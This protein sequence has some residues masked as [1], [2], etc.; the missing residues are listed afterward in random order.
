MVAASADVG[1]CMIEA[2]SLSDYLCLPNKL[3][4]YAFA[5]LPVIASKFPDIAKVVEGYGLGVCADI[6]VDS[7]SSAMGETCRERRRVQVDLINNLSWQAQAARL[8]ALY[9]E[10]FEK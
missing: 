10:V 5:G 4:E 1:L 9:L 6:D 2:V 3:F 8:N 7:I